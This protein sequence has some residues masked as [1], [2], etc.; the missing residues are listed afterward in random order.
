MSD[1]FLSNLSSLSFVTRYSSLRPNFINDIV[2]VNHC[3]TGLPEH[4]LKKS[5]RAGQQWD[6]DK[7]WVQRNFP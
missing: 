1:N 4:F 2:A 6:N 3:Q 7:K 5:R